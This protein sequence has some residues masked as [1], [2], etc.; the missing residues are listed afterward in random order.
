MTIE[1]DK[2]FVWPKEPESWEPWG[3]EEKEKG[4]KDSV[5]E[6]QPRHEKQKESAEALREHA[7]EVLR[8][9]GGSRR[10]GNVLEQWEKRR[11][12]KFVSGDDA[13]YKIRV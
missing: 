3:K 1:M 12:G 4:E 11:T 7:V 2:P 9:E 10:T 5:D 13:E 8:G 6:M